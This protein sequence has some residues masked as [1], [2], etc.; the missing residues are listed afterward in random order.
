MK[1][2]RDYV[3]LQKFEA[4]KNVYF[5]FKTNNEGQLSLHADVIDI[6]CQIKEDDVG[7]IVENLLMTFPVFGMHEFPK[8]IR[9]RKAANDIARRS[10]RGAGNTTWNNI[11]FYKNS[12]PKFADVDAPIIVIEKDG[13]FGVFKHP[14]FEKYGVVL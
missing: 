10:R 2:W 8:E 4:T 9:H 12:G 1:N 11:L 5:I 7:E 6:D 3:G 14:N 13:L